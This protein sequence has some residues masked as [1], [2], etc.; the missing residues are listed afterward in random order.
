MTE[1]NLITPDDVAQMLAL[2]KRTL[3]RA[4]KRGSLEGFPEPY[5]YSEKLTRWNRDEVQKWMEERRAPKV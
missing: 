4:L 5:R 1:H 2:S 3:Y